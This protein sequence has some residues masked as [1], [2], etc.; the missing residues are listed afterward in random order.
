MKCN[1]PAGIYYENCFG[2]RSLFAVD[3]GCRYPLPFSEQIKSVI[4]A[5]RMVKLVFWPGKYTFVRFED[6]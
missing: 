4:K 2:R 6:C 1:L 5:T 3:G